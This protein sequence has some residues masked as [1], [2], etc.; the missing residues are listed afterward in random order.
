MIKYFTVIVFF[1]FCYHPGM[2]QTKTA[3]SLKK[4]L[5][6]AKNPIQQFDA[7]NRLVLEYVGWKGDNVDSTYSIQMLQIAQQMH[8]DSLLAISYNWLGSYFYL[9][10]GDNATGLEYFYKALPY[11]LKVDDKRRI[12]SLYFDIALVYFDLLNYEGALLATRKG[13]QSLPAQ[14]HPMYDFML[15]QYQ[16]NMADYFLRVS[17]LDSAFFYANELAK[18]VDRVEGISYE[19]S[20]HAIKGAAHAQAGNVEK[21]DEEFDKLFTA[22]PTTKSS[23]SNMQF[24]TYYIPFL[25]QNNRIT[26][27]GEQ[28]RNLLQLGIQYE[29]NNLKLL[30]AGF[31]RQV[32]DAR[33]QLDSAY[34]YSKME[35]SINA[36]IFSQNNRNRIQALAFN[37]QLRDM[38]AKA[39]EEAYQNQIRLYGLLAGIGVVLVIVF[40]LFRNNRQKQKAN[41][42][43]EATLSNLKSTQSQLIQ[44]EKM[45]SLGELTAGI[46]HEIQNPLNF[47]NNFSEV[48]KELAD[49]LAE[50]IENGNYN[51]AKTLAKDIKENQEKIN[52]HG[53]RADAIVKG[54]LQHSRSSNG[55]KVPTNINVLA[56][57]Y[58]RLAYHGLRAKDKS[59]NAVMRTE[60]DDTIEKVNVIPQDI[61]RVILNLI[62]NAFYAV[63]DKKKSATE[64]YEPVVTVSTKKVGNG[65]E[66]TVKDNGNGIPDSI[67]DKVFQPFFTTKPTGQGTGLGL[68]LSY[69]IVKAHGGELKVES[70]EGEGSEFI[71]ELPIV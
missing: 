41:Q 54:M 33:K 61:G 53:K 71:V 24:Y 65:I 25:L 69:D 46:A 52:H 64:G 59:F 49:E 38:E 39:K 37:D 56:D 19:F 62:T 32:Y 66:V 57:E 55:V 14:S 34:F 43:L 26:E 45:A 29:N 63:N 48:N 12:S 44:S 8:N 16:G 60:F 10:K 2:G 40:I 70:K 42:V 68:S 36:E 7:L 17:Q 47:V 4:V 28:A 30:G 13:G 15:M 20:V 3:D 21:A 35:A 31:L 23:T 22:L 58:L 1:T 67:K 18:T 5:A 9:N 51:E 50:E 11:A 6:I 27:A